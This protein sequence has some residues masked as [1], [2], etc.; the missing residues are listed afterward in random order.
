[1]SN[2]SWV[3]FVTGKILPYIRI[4]N[5][6]ISDYKG[7]AFLFGEISGLKPFPGCQ[8]FPVHEQH[9]GIQKTTRGTGRLLF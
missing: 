2:D 4:S 8:V 6:I 7:F 5:C 1:N 9:A 3:Q